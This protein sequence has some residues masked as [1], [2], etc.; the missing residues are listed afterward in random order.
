[1][2]RVE[3]AFETYPGDQMTRIAQH[4]SARQIPLG[5]EPSANPA[6]EAA[7]RA[8]FRRLEISR[9][10]TFEQAVSDTAYAI[11]IRNLAEAIARRI[12]RAQKRGAARRPALWRTRP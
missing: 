6:A 1:M 11:G 3:A 4:A 5:L 8:A 7:Q 2:R 9:R 12:N 10:L